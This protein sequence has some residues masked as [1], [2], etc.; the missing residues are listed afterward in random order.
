MEADEEVIKEAIEESK[1]NT[2]YLEDIIRRKQH[3][4]HPEVEK[5]I[6]SPI[7]YLRCTL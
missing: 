1:E 3:A 5:S 2:D 4:L 7:Q 6:I